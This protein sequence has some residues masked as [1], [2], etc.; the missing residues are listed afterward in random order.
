MPDKA[1]HFIQVVGGIAPPILVALAGGAVRVL[2]G[3]GPC[4]LRYVAA[5]VITAAFTGYLTHSVLTSIHLVPDGVR[6]ACVG[7]AGYAG[8][9]LLDILAERFC[10]VAASKVDRHLGK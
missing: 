10:K 8:G 3:P 7:I 5:T 9:K 6:T 4:S 1:T 2:R